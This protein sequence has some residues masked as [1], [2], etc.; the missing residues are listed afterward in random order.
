LPITEES[1]A[2]A[3]IS[4]GSHN[5][6][7][8]FAYGE[9]GMLYYSPKKFR[10]LMLYDLFFNNKS[11]FLKPLQWNLSRNGKTDAFTKS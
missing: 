5:Q 6:Q 3:L 7:I 10:M 4:L 9:I 8:Y 1:F 2:V 11:V